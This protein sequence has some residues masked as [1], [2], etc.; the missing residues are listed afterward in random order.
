[1]QTGLRYERRSL[2]NGASVCFVI[3]PQSS[4]LYIAVDFAFGSAHERPHQYGGTHALEH[5]FFLGTETRDR[6]ALWNAG[7]AWRGSR[8]AATM[9]HSTVFDCVN[10]RGSYAATPGRGAA[11]MRDAQAMIDHLSDMLLRPTLPADVIRRELERV[12]NEVGYSHDNGQFFYNHIAPFF[13]DAPYDRSI[14]GSKAE[15]R[16][17]TRDD[18]VSLY[19]RMVVSGNATIW[20]AAPEIDIDGVMVHLETR[21]A[22]MLDG[23]RAPVL[24]C[25]LKESDVRQNVNF[26]EQ[27][28]IDILLAQTP[29]TDPFMAATQIAAR[30][31]MGNA[32]DKAMDA[33]S[34]SYVY[35]I[36]SLMEP[37][38]L[39][40]NLT[41]YPDPDDT[42]D[43]ARHFMDV[44][45]GI[46]RHVAPDD[47]EAHRRGRRYTLMTD[48][49]RSAFAA[50]AEARYC[51]RHF[52][53]FTLAAQQ[54]PAAE[55]LNFETVRAALDGLTTRPIGTVAV[56]PK[57]ETMPSLSALTPR[58]RLAAE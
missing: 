30:T 56:G 23:P 14:A 55:A 26:F 34:S 20:V 1:M 16:R 18:L 13:F 7:R 9:K 38:A 37:G 49:P 39:V 15:V 10:G 36:Q 32:L 33:S 21:F 43:C 25:L 35:T 6:E 17:L 2:S 46:G 28:R 19:E 27:N 42:Y 51:Q 48:N 53:D 47:L 45:R 40:Y 8:N 44:A 52:G 50:C 4:N 12:A 3:A 29:P 5:A 58:L 11:I 41:A 24:P 54:G 57:P 31:L 22:S